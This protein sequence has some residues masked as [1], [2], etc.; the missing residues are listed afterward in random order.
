MLGVG[1]ALGAV[2]LSSIGNIVFETKALSRFA[3]LDFSPL[4]ADF[5]SWMDTESM[6]QFH[7][8]AIDKQLTQVRAIDK[9]LTQVCSNTQGRDTSGSTRISDSAPSPLVLITLHPPPCPPQVYRVMAI[10][11]MLNRTLVSG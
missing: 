7:L 11:T 9:Q 2:P 3:D 8:R 10:A 6:I 5:N 1:G 4:P